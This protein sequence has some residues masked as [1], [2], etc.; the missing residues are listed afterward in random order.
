MVSRHIGYLRIENCRSERRD[1]IILR[2]A[3]CAGCV[4]HIP[5]YREGFSKGLGARVDDEIIASVEIHRVVSLFGYP[6]IFV[7]GILDSGCLLRGFAGHILVAENGRDFRKHS[8]CFIVNDGSGESLRLVYIG[9]LHPAGMALLAP[10]D[11]RS[12]SAHESGFGA[13]DSLCIGLK[14]SAD[15]GIYEFEPF[16][17]AGHFIDFPSGDAPYLAVGRDGPG[18]AAAG[19]LNDASQRVYFLHQ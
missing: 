11:K 10:V 12:F 3:L 19:V 7:D 8:P 6:E 5:H 2:D 4:G 16:P 13:V 18:S 1:R 17:V 14:R 15:H 9:A